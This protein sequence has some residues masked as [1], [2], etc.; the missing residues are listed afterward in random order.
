MKGWVRP[1]PSHLGQTDGG[2]VEPFMS[3]TDARF[4]IYCGYL[5]WLE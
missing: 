4:L 1:N 3:G 2:V 5:S